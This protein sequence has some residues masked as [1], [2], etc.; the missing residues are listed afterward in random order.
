MAELALYYSP[1]A[2][3]LAAHIALQE[4]GRPFEA[5]RVLIAKGEH[6]SPD[7]LALNPQGRIPL[8]LVDGHPIRENSGILTW[9][10]QQAGLYPERGSLEAARCAELLGWLTSGVHISFALIW[11]GERFI[12]DKR[13]YPLLRA[14][15]L[16]ALQSQFRDIEQG[17][18]QG[19]YWLGESYS[20]ADCN[21]FPF[22]R[23]G[24]RVGFDMEAEFPA[25]SAH[26]QRLLARPAVAKTV[27]AEGIEMKLPPDPAP[28]SRIRE[29]DIAAFDAAW[30]AGDLERLMNYIA[31]DCVYAASV[32][33]EPGQTFVGRD[34][35]KAGF[36]KM[37]EH[38]RTRR[39]QSG[40]L[41]FFGDF[42]FAEWSFAEETPEGQQT[43]K[44]I[45]RFEFSPQGIVRKDAYRKTKAG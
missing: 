9:I 32:G 12:D 40:P 15:G 33:P 38:D 45:D 4:W 43:I 29:E 7:Y 37:L 6:L 44:G 8:L 3:S 11:R 13:L 26:V 31:P 34:A 5:R 20:V 42:A 18:Q 36:E 25:W 23:W 1:G 41:W 30:T 22:Y 28:A 24:W 14:R 19:P 17:L 10:G 39:R 2:C 35:V 27:A 21:L 16:A